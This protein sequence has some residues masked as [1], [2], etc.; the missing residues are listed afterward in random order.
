[1]SKFEKYVMK[2]KDEFLKD[3]DKL[4]R[5]PSIRDETSK[6]EGAPFGEKIH[7]SFLV[8]ADIASK[9]GLQTHDFEG[10]A[11]HAFT[12]EETPYIGVLGHLDVVGVDDK[13]N[14]DPF[15]LTQV[16][17][18]LYGRGVNDD[19]GPLLAALYA[20]RILR[21]QGLLKKPV[22]IIAGGAEETTWECMDY[23]FSKNKQPQWAFSPDGNF[24]I[25]NGEKG[26]LQYA[27]NFSLS[28]QKEIEIQCVNELNYVCDEVKIKIY[29]DYKDVMKYAKHAFK[30]NEKDDGTEIIYIGKKALS[31]NPHKGKNALFAFFSDFEKYPFQNDETKRLVKLFTQVLNEDIYGKKL[32]IFTED[33]NMGV[34]TICPMV[35]AWNAMEQVVY[36]DIRFVR[37][38]EKMD[39]EKKIQALGEQFGFS[40]A[41]IKEKRLLYVDANSPL[42][43]SLQYA[44]KEVM[45]EEA[46]LISKGGASYARVLDHGVVFGATFNDYD[47]RV[48]MANECMPL[49]DLLKAMEIFCVAIY[50][51][52]NDL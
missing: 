5:I 31:R 22:R 37:G 42:I 7:D 10:Y 27:F 26:I 50:R 36:L 20:L 4:I 30:I 28:N 14:Y 13:W 15:A 33:E 25:V 2:Y 29:K 19:K 47:T 46:S 51:L 9:C 44:Y 18:L 48:H 21:E 11:I 8:F 3:L 1:M 52:S 34:T 12:S 41:L 32:G 24:P 43:S 40:Y 38:I 6:R 35:I 45:K 49:A 17:Q 39:I 16:K 23:Y